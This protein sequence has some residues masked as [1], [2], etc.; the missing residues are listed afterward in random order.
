MPIGY[1]P[2]GSQK[3]ASVTS[4]IDYTLGVS[5]EIDKWS[6]K[7]GILAVQRASKKQTLTQEQAI[8]IG[9]A[10]RSRLLDFT[11]FRGTDLHQAY[12]NIN[13]NLSYEVAEHDMP[14]YTAYFNWRQQQ[15]IEPILEEFRIT[16]HQH[17]YAGRL[18]L[19]CNLN[20]KRTLLDYKNSDKKMYPAKLFR[21]GLQLT[22]YKECLEKAGYP[23]EQML[24]IAVSGKQR[25]GVGHVEV[26]EVTTPFQ[27]FEWLLGLYHL[28]LTH[29]PYVKWYERTDEAAIANEKGADIKSTPVSAPLS[30]VQGLNPDTPVFSPI[31]F[32]RAAQQ[33]EELELAGLRQV[34]T[35]NG[36]IHIPEFAFAQDSP[37]IHNSSP[38]ASPTDETSSHKTVI[39]PESMTEASRLDE[40]VVVRFSDAKLRILLDPSTPPLERHTSV[41]RPVDS[42]DELD[43]QPP[44]RP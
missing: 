20:G 10:E 12:Q 3:L 30:D 9:L 33:F 18:D 21:Y 34:S 28:K 22:A 37:T 4:I 14:F 40:G 42:D 39:Q 13:N 17:G 38:L 5:D 16:N 15:K 6:L 44:H 27:A 26:Y 32:Q 41:P 29:D 35:P 25:G 31:P 1:Y 24:I 43:S 7:Q 11:R 19:Y 36:T 23:V 8:E 2:D